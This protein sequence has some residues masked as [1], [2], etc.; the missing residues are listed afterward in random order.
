MFCGRRPR[1][2]T[3]A[4]IRRRESWKS[5]KLMCA[6]TMLSPQP[7]EL[8]PSKPEPQYLRR[9]VAAASIRRSG[10]VVSWLEVL[11]RHVVTSLLP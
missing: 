4:S 11:F 8:N 3:F 2:A 6:R 10:S 9:Y 5:S 1:T 7:Q